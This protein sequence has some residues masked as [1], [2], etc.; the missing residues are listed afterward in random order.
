MCCSVVCITPFA[1]CNIIVVQFI[2]LLPFYLKVKAALPPGAEDEIILIEHLPG[3][4]VHLQDFFWTGLEDA[5]PWIDP[6]Q[7]L[8]YYE[9]RTV[10]H[11]A[12]VYVPGEDVGRGKDSGSGTRDPGCISC[13]EPTPTLIDPDQEIGIFIGEDPD[14]KY[15]LLTVLKA[16]ENVP[17]RVELRL[18]RLYRAAFTRQ[19]QRHLGLLTTDPRLR[20]ATNKKLTPLDDDKIVSREFTNN[21]MKNELKNTV[22]IASSTVVPE[23]I[24]NN[25]LT[26]YIEVEKKMKEIKILNISHENKS[27]VISENLDK[28]LVDNTESKLTLN[29]NAIDVKP[30]ITSLKNET[31]E[32]LM[33]KIVKN[34]QALRSNPDHYYVD[35]NEDNIKPNTNVNI[36]SKTEIERHEQTS[37]NDTK[38]NETKVDIND[39]KIDIVNNQSSLSTVKQNI[40]SLNNKTE[41]YSS[42]SRLKTAGTGIVQ[43]KMQNTSVQQD[44]ST[45]LIYSVHLGGKPVPAETAAKDMALLSSQEVALE[46]GV[47]VIIQSQPY[48]KETQPLALS[49]KPE[50][51][52]LISTAGAI[53][54]LLTLIIIGIILIARKKKIHSTVSAPPTQSILKKE[55]G[56]TTSTP[57]LDNTGYTSETEGRTDGTSQRRTP[58]S[59]SRTPGTPITPNTIDDDIQE[60]SSDEDEEAKKQIQG[61]WDI[62]EYP[63]LPSK[64]RT[65]RKR[66][67]KM[68][69]IETLDSPN[70]METVANDNERG[71]C[72]ENGYAHHLEETASPHSYLSMPPCKLF[73]SMRSVEPLSRILEPVVVRHLDMEFETPEMTRRENGFIN[74]KLGDESLG[75]T[76]S[77]VKDPGVVG[78]IVWDLRRQRAVE[79]NLDTEMDVERQ[80]P[81]SG[82]VGR[83]RRRLHELLEDSF[84]LFTAKDIKTKE[85]N[86]S[87]S[88]HS[89]GISHDRVTTCLESKEKCTLVSPA[90]SPM[91]QTRMRPRTSLPR[92]ILEESIPETGNTSVPTRGAWGSRPMSAGPFHRPNLPEVNVTR[93]LAD[94]HLAPDDPAVPLIAAIRKELEKFTPDKI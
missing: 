10:H 55:A 51:W 72:L 68:N 83:A 88:S 25:N 69:A 58:G 66:I 59:F 44:G 92:D 64:D 94:T 37:L 46:L 13:I 9:T 61:S 85:T 60:L 21:S 67:T 93:V 2:I 30:A 52:L 90:E 19:Q 71:E 86:I 43:V 84:S 45:K 26:S 77:A 38:S 11:T 23:S 39:E 33:E 6:E 22:A 15:W 18:A 47:P 76:R 1:C 48:L 41:Y 57:G 87:V 65:G 89:N 29:N 63:T 54:I 50:V 12:T 40:S 82:P 79:E 56:Y 35:Y 27:T 53:V 49:R 42:S 17:S 24:V 34:P 78:P 70:S 91:D 75:R 73:P 16:G 4:R 80:L 62:Q 3:R 36:N 7:T 14:P 81:L 31:S 5:P 32:L 74:K 20:R 8:T 28:K